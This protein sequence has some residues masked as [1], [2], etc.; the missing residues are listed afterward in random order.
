MPGTRKEFYPSSDHS[1]TANYNNI[2][3]SSAFTTFLGGSAY[4]TVPFFYDDP[5]YNSNSRPRYQLRFPQYQVGYVRIKSCPDGGDWTSGVTTVG[6]TTSTS[7]GNGGVGTIKGPNDDA[8]NNI[9]SWSDYQG[10][11]FGGFGSAV[12]ISPK[13]DKIS[14]SAP[15]WNPTSYTDSHS[16]RILYYEYNPI[17]GN[18]E[19]GTRPNFSTFIQ[20]QH[21]Y[22]LAMGTDASRIFAS[23]Y[24]SKNLF[25]PYDYSGTEWYRAAGIKEGAS[26]DVGKIQGFSLATKSGNRVIAGSP[27]MPTGGYTTR[28]G[29]VRIYEYPL[30]SVFRGNSLFEGYIKADEIVVGSTTNATNTKRLLFGGTKGDNEP[31]VSSMEVRH[32]GT[33]GDRDSE[34]L[35][36]KWYGPTSDG[37]M[38]V[39]WGSSTNT[40]SDSMSSDRLLY[41]DRLRLKAPKIEFHLQPSNAFYDDQKY[42]EHPI[43]TITS[44]DPGLYGSTIYPPRFLTNIRSGSTTSTKYAGLRL[45]SASGTSWNGSTHGMPADGDYYTFSPANDGWLRLYGGASGQSNMSGSYAGLAVGNLYVAGS[46]SGPGASSGGGGGGGGTSNWVRAYHTTGGGISGNWIP[47]NVDSNNTSGIYNSSTGIYTC[48]S[49]GWYTID[50]HLTQDMLNQQSTTAA[51]VMFLK[52]NTQF[53]RYFSRPLAGV[54]SGTSTPYS[55][56]APY[57]VINGHELV[58]CNTNDQLRFIMACYNLYASGTSGAPGFSIY[59]IS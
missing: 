19:E 35:I 16:G 43:V 47:P 10:N 31:N 26:A 56:L 28:T 57:H 54:Y 42:S 17:S 45:T 1:G 36:S 18:W 44:Q 39:P 14:A 33:S 24:D 2:V 34:I 48:P 50:F 12:Q 25:L 55:G 30:T 20:Q 51:Y 8:N 40:W 49:A 23:F 4:S 32:L 46:I 21:G 15:G 38:G 52:N 6:G 3:Y 29:E 27:G 11:S 59:K 58:Y 5:N 22:A 41:G 53:Q 9:G 13:G 7:S 37:A